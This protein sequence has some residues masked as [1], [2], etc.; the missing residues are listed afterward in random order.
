[1]IGKNGQKPI[2]YF[3]ASVMVFLSFVCIEW[4]FGYGMEDDQKW[5]FIA[6]GTILIFRNYAF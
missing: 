4:S 5:L 2:P 1:M 3:L 6:I